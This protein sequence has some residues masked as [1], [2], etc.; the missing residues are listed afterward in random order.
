MTTP[1]PLSAETIREWV[2]DAERYRGYPGADLPRDRILALAAEVERLREALS[3]AELEREEA[4]EH[5]ARWLDEHPPLTTTERVR[6]GST[7]DLSV[8]MMRYAERM[9]A[10][11][12]QAEAA[13]KALRAKTGTCEGDGEARCFCEGGD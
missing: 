2:A 3:V 12:E 8:D 6:R 13:L 10:R 7:G 5:I 9:K 4:Q 11:A 1:E